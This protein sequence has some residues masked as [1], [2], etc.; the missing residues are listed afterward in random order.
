MAAQA[1]IST[2]T[3]DIYRQGDSYLVHQKKANRFVRMGGRELLVLLSALHLNAENILTENADPLDSEQEEILVRKFHASGLLGDAEKSK[4]RRDLSDLVL[5]SVE[6]RPATL[7]ILR[8]MERVMFPFGAA[9]L[10]AFTIAAFVLMFLYPQTYL[11][12]YN[13]MISGMTPLRLFLLYVLSLPC[14][15]IHE[16][17]HCAA[18]YHYTGGCG[19]IGLKLYYGIP[20]FFSDVSGMYTI[21]DRKKE[22]VV[23]L[24]GVTS[25]LLLFALFTI[26]YVF[27][28]FSAAGM[29]CLMIAGLNLGL[30]LFNL[31]PLA[32]FDGYWAIKSLSGIDNLFD[33]AVSMAFCLVL[34]PR[35][36]LRLPIAPVK[37]II[38]TVYGLLC[39]FFSYYLWYLFLQ[40]IHSLLINWQVAGIP[41]YCVMSVF[42]FVALLNVVASI[43]KHIKTYMLHCRQVR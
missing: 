25:N 8:A 1:V 35:A 23:A 29:V 6:Q 42:L 22:A 14:A 18:C 20:A 37:K 3:L 2:D 34:R 16:L 7:R 17:A 38:L 9:I 40:V 13:A 4:K 11:S 43:R 24:S 30:G 12:G 5:C 10:G 36:L 21:G 33:K 15:I 32:R 31:I 26:I 41:Y 19:K 27:F 28:P 39:Y